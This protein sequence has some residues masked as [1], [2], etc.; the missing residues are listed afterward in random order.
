VT[1]KIVIKD[2]VLNGFGCVVVF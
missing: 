2:P 1:K